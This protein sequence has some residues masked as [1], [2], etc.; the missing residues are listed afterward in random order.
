MKITRILI[1][2]SIVRDKGTSAG[3]SQSS[4]PIVSGTFHFDET[5][6]HI[7]HDRKR[8]RTRVYAPFNTVTQ[9][10]RNEKNVEGAFWLVWSPT[11]LQIYV[12]ERNHERLEYTSGYVL[13]CF[14]ILLPCGLARTHTHTHTPTHTYRFVLL[15]LHLPP[16]LRLRSLSTEYENYF[17]ALYI[18]QAT[19][20]R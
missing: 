10:N 8:E 20:S 19:T 16:V 17:S 1:I 12:D 13:V 11:R 4:L 7:V 5:S 14:C 9:S 2:W 18:H 15:S 3:K 6:C